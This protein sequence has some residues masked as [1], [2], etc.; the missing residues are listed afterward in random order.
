MKYFINKNK[1]KQ[2]KNSRLFCRW[3]LNFKKHGFLTRKWRS[4]LNIIMIL[5]ILNDVQ[6]ELTIGG[7][8]AFTLHLTFESVPFTAN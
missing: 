6:I 8:S 1:Y 5:I 7:G 3:K 2:C 4:Q